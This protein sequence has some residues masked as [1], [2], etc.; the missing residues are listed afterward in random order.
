MNLS[1]QRSAS[2]DNKTH[3]IAD[4]CA[5]IFMPFHGQR[6]FICRL[7][8]CPS[9]NMNPSRKRDISEAFSENFFTFGKFSFLI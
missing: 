9:V 3:Q 4:C 7:S 1:V 2:N 5:F 6:L 8:V